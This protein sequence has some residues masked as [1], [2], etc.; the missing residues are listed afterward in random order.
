MSFFKS[1]RPR[2]ALS[3]LILSLF[4]FAASTQADVVILKSGERIEG[5]VLLS[6][7]KE[8]VI[9]TRFSDSITNQERYPKSSV[10][11]VVVVSKDQQAFAEL[12][13]KYP[14]P[15]NALEASDF[16][17]FFDARRKFLSEFAYSSKV[18]I[19]REQ[20]AK[21][22]KELARVQ[23]GEVKIDGRW[24]T[25]EEIKEESYQINALRQFK[26]MES[27]RHSGDLISALNAFAVIEKE[28]PHSMVYPE[29]VAKAR[30]Y[31]EQL[32]KILQHELRNFPLRQAEREKQIAIETPENQAR[33]RAARREELERLKAQAEQ[34]AARGEK[35]FRY[36]KIDEEGM[37]KLQALA[38]QEKARLDGIDLESMQRSVKATRLCIKLLDE[39]EFQAAKT[40]AE[41]ALADWEENELAQRMLAR[42][43]AEIEARASAS[44]AQKKAAQKAAENQLLEEQ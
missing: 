6:D 2:S 8:V 20:I 12:E 21:G 19:V 9:E 18:G 40:E 31:A 10:A 30:E 23:A 22:E 42:V 24:L 43:N 35:F 25:P 1:P 39:R 26:A 27:A 14:L 17:E 38:L 32:E 44:A 13:E 7:D 4:C 11:R 37:K 33:I 34:A 41:K 36:S 15:S 5:K 28:Y 16:E 3:F 29:A